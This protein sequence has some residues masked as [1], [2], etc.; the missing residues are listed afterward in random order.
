MNKTLFILA[1][2]TLVLTFLVVLFGIPKN[3]LAYTYNPL[4]E[5]QIYLSTTTRYL[6]IPCVP[7]ISIYGDSRFSISKYENDFRPSG[8]PNNFCT[9]NPH[10]EQFGDHFNGTTDYYAGA[11]DLQATTTGTYYLYLNNASTSYI[12]FIK[13]TY[14][15]A[16]TTTL[17]FTASY[18]Q[19]RII[20]VT[21]ASKSTNA[22]S[23]NF[24][25]NITGYISDADIGRPVT[26]KLHSGL[27]A[28]E[29]Y[30]N[31]VFYNNYLNF[32][33]VATSSGLFNYSTT[34]NITQIGRYYWLAELV[35]PRYVFG[36][37]ISDYDLVA[38]TST[39]LVATSSQADFIKGEPFNI[40]DVA[41][42]VGDECTGSTNFFLNLGTCIYKLVIPDQTQIQM[43]YSDFR[44]KMLVKAPFGYGTRIFDI[45]MGDT[46]STTLVGLN[47]T[48]PSEL[49]LPVSGEVAN[50]DPWGN[51]AS[52]VTTLNTDV[53]VGGTI[54]ILQS[55]L[56][57][58]NIA[59]L[60]LFGLWIYKV[61]IKESHKHHK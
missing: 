48:I 18:L 26:V 7:S 16:S 55:L 22:T 32:S 31:D 61:I 50:F 5:S 17:D 51:L 3:L 59:C 56:Y 38:T 37:H 8:P 46:A 23:T 27:N 34:T 57:Y 1:K 41:N 45:F 43:I 47:L 39:F 28:S 20:S 25:F 44:D 11:F 6:A 10:P 4:Q 42:I 60:T 21:P 52:A 24:S 29:F 2:S 15:G 19:T 53:P 49:N 12:D 58:W 35:V 36:F 40:E 30:S 54:P 14:D 33:I 13:F 9:N